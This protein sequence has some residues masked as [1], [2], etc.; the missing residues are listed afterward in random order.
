MALSG[1]LFNMRAGGG[2][3]GGTG[4]R[5]A[6]NSRPNFI[7]ASGGYNYRY[8]YVRGEAASE[9]GKE[10]VLGK[11]P[12]NVDYVSRTPGNATV[13]VPSGWTPTYNAGFVRGFLDGG[14]QIRLTPG[15]FSGTF[16]LEVE[17]VLTIPGAP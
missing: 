1:A 15:E 9:A 8:G 2:N 11:Y 3:G 17:Q 5:F 4:S 10:L 7:G 13:D 16:K 12:G 14:G 6:P